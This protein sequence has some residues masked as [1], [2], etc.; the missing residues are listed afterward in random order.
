MI[1]AILQDCRWA[2]R[3]LRRSPGFSGVVVLTVAIALGANA[4]LF[5]VM[6]ALILRPLPVSD[7][8]RLELLTLVDQRDRRN[9]IPLPTIAE[10]AKHLDSIEVLC[11]YS[12]GGVFIA[13]AG[14]TLLQT[15]LD[16]VGSNCF[17]ALGVQPLIGRLIDTHDDPTSGASPHVVVLGYGYWQRVFG[18]DPTALGRTLLV[19][20]V[21][22]QVIG[23]TRPEY[24]GIS[25]DVAADIVVPVALVSE[26][27]G[28]PANP[29][30]PIR[31][32][33]MVGRLRQGA[34]F[35]QAQAEI[36]ARWPVIR[37]ATVPPGYTP[38]EQGTYRALNIRMTSLSTG[39]S[40]LRTRYAEPLL[41]LL[42]L[43]GALLLIGCTN[44]AGLFLVRADERS[45]E[46]SVAIALGSGPGRL[47]QQ[48]V[49]ESLV[50][51]GIGTAV[52]LPLAWSAS[53][54]LASVMWTGIVP[55]ALSLTPDGRVLAATAAV[56]ITISFATGAIPA[57]IVYR[58]TLAGPQAL[59]SV[60]RRSSRIGKTLVVTQVALSLALLFGATLFARSL[61]NLRA[62]D[63]GFRPTNVLAGRLQ[64]RPG[65][66]GPLDRA[67]Y[68]RDLIG[69]L[70]SQPGIRSAALVHLFPAPI[71]NPQMA[72]AAGAAEHAPEVTA[73]F[74]QVS[75]GFFRTI[76]ASVLAGRDFD[77]SD[78]A[79]S[80]AVAIIS[81]N[82]AHR[83]FP[84]RDFIGRQIRIG[85]NPGSQAVEIVGVVGD[86][87]LGDVREA[88]PPAVFRP[89]LQ[90]PTYQVIPVLLVQSESNS[91]A[92]VD[93]VRKTVWSLGQEYAPNLMML[94]EQMSQFLLQERILAA[95]SSVFGG[96]AS[97]LAFLG[98]FALL[99][100]T[101]TLKTREIGVRVALGA[102]TGGIL[103]MVVLHGFM[104]AAIGVVAGVPLAL[105]AGRIAR[106]TLFGLS[107]SD[108]FAV[109]LAAGT[110]LAIG[111]LAGWLPAR[112]AARIDPVIALRAE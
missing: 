60:A 77:W 36:T 29:R 100:H 98:L 66:H 40:T 16:A 93:D 74:E 109:G 111:L 35:A 105:A 14:G 96:L 4:T 21:P 33:Y 95:L 6:N 104:L 38:A 43:A 3:R 94:D 65:S 19:E 46:L 39:M 92:L 107:W 61:S 102:T 99:A 58:R 82:L 24:T 86:I 70:E 85:T 49:T 69:R 32:T 5:S 53:K 56:A 34:T 27:L 57:W 50:L 83:V 62:V 37:G 73:A 17:A 54:T 26:L 7:P 55:L 88:A 51:C 103:R 75:P 8:K 9:N 42:G 112:S 80:R 71:I 31:S 106:S 110:F 1:D 45:H 22:L 90:E 68:S 67:S 89:L 12:T 41:M 79:S 91:P 23:V 78:N 76:G 84:S 59:R 108:P 30:R 44:L 48:A 87:R 97:L 101:V 10:A 72:T 11:P 81:E 63:L 13:E 28:Q 15:T 20:G 64:S 18:S 52:A 25:I 47:I 2:V